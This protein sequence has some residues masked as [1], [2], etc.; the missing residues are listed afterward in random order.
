MGLF[1]K[2][3]GKIDI[4]VE[5]LDIPQTESSDISTEGMDTDE[6]LALAQKRRQNFSEKSRNF[7]N[8]EKVLPNELDTVVDGNVKNAQ[9][10]LS[11]VA[12][13]SK[14]HENIEDACFEFRVKTFRNYNG[15]SDADE[16]VTEISYLNDLDFGKPKGDLGCFLNYQKYKVCGIDED[17]KTRIK[18][19]IGVNEERAIKRVE[20]EGLHGPFE[21]EII[22]HDP[23]TERQLACLERNGFICPPG[24]TKD[25][26]SYIIGRIIDEDFGV[27]SL[28]LVSLAQRLNIEFS[29]FASSKDLYESV[30]YA[31]DIRDRAALYIYAVCQNYNN[32]PFRNMFETPNI[33][34]FYKFADAVVDDS[35]LIRSLKK[36]DADDFEKPRKGTDIYKSAMAFLKDN[37]VLD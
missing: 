28:W 4:L 14:S 29:I 9:K 35:K 16:C 24:L 30:I 2:L 5:K 32:L 34:L 33:S 8:G 31:S 36:R 6:L 37:R 15:E 20:K 26:A 22:E 18:I 23:P 10:K 13:E 1:N 27:P 11:D 21:I 17:G 19:R 12:T 7:D 3:K 25:D